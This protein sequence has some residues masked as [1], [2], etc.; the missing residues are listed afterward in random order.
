VDTP[1]PLPRTNRTRRVPHPAPSPDP[2]RPAARL[3]D[4]RCAGSFAELLGGLHVTY[5]G[6]AHIFPYEI[7]SYRCAAAPPPAS[8]PSASHLAGL[9]VLR[10]NWELCA[11]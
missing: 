10:P 3:A 9:A 7:A 2:A 4:Q 8:P 11:L 5:M 6:K 1:R